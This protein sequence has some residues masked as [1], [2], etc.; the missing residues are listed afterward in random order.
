V[1]DRQRDPRALVIGLTIHGL[2][3]TRALARAGVHVDVLAQGSRWRNAAAFTRY[4]RVHFREGLNTAA[5]RDHL[6]E[7][8]ST[9]ADGRPIVL[10][11]TSDRMA[12]TIARHWPE[13]A[14]RYRL[15]WA[16]C[17]DLVVTLQ[18]KANLPAYAA[19]AGVRHPRSHVVAGAADATVPGLAFPVVVKPTQP[20]SSFKALRADSPAD[21]AAIVARYPGELPFVVQELVEGGADALWAVT[22]YLDR[23][24]EAGALVS[25]KLAAS[26][27]GFGQGTVFAVEPNA[28]VL[29]LGRQF[30]A[31]LGLSGPV[32]VEFKR[33]PAG[34][35][36]LIEPNA[37]RTEYC[38]DLAIQAG[39]NLPV[40][41]YGH[42]A[43]MAP[44]DQR[45]DPAPC[46][47]FD[48]DKDPACHATFRREHPD[49]AALPAV[50]PFRGHD[51][52][53]PL[54]VAGAWRGAGAA[55]RTLARILRGG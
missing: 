14:A 4:A 49:R 46:A 19:R 30:V 5:L 52:A 38:V 6:R 27:P 1:F 7:F 13:L 44:P 29:A 9:T 28:E 35:F 51:D 36:W 16:D 48:T 15:S 21:V 20:L 45:P 53:L 33:D 3:V 50:F 25:R 2:A 41:E 11:P 32:A 42:A 54:L 12:A 31:G 18:D 37:G 8:A 22:F 24:R 34:T 40:I 43:G 26:P 23:G 17:R 55:K 10:F 39:L 47:W